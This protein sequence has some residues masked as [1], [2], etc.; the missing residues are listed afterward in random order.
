MPKWSEPFT[1]A[2][3]KAGSINGSRSIAGSAVTTGVNDSGKPLTKREEA[4]IKNKRNVLAKMKERVANEASGSVA[5]EKA[6]TVRQH[7]DVDD[8]REVKRIKTDE[9]RVGDGGQ[10]EMDQS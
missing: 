1:A 10:D 7:E 2:S 5:G 9:S 8:D 6:G 3:E 4:R